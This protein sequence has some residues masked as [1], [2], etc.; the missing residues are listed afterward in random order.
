[1]ACFEHLDRNH[2]QYCSCYDAAANFFLYLQY[3][4]S[5]KSSKFWK[6]NVSKYGC[7]L[8]LIILNSIESISL[9]I[10]LWCL[11]TIP[12]Y[13][14]CIIFKLHVL[15][16]RCD[17]GW[18]GNNCQEPTGTLPHYLYDTFSTII[19]STRLWV[20]V[21]GA[22]VRKPCQVLAAGTALHFVEVCKAYS[23]ILIRG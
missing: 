8:L 11:D 9:K 23:L 6:K 17:K 21:I 1:M 10:Q 13:V 19:P 5:S 20:K 12:L 3:W 4:G 2:Y 18:A 22:K 16:C 15:Y 14:L 7:Y